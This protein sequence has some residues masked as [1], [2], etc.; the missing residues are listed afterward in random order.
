MV[1]LVKLWRGARIDRAG[2]AYVACCFVATA[3]VAALSLP[4]IAFNLTRLGLWSQF[5]PLP[6]IARG[7]GLW[8]ALSLLGMVA[9]LPFAPAATW[10]GARLR[11]E[12]AFYYAAVGGLA[13]CVLLFLLIGPPRETDFGGEIFAWAVGPACAAAWGGAWWM[14]YRRWIVRAKRERDIFG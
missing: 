10:L 13:V 8:L 1:V 4:V 2:P 14:L 3:A 5:D 12:N 6:F 7:V 9:A 11:I